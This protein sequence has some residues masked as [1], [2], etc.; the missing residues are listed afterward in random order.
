MIK[1]KLFTPEQLKEV[2]EVARTQN[3][4]KTA[5][6]FKL[7]IES[8]KRIRKAQPKLESALQRGLQH[9]DNKIFTEEEL[10]EVEELAKTNNADNVSKHFNIKLHH[11]AALKRSQ[12]E[13]AKAYQRGVK[14]R[15]YGTFHVGRTTNTT[16]LDQL[17]KPIKITEK[18]LNMSLRDICPQQALSQYM[19]MK[20]A[21]KE[22][23]LYQELREMRNEDL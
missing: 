16:K 4:F 7:N 18:T 11:F 1:D 12:P 13:L 2:E 5:L 23:R 10:L 3:I 14:Q 9:S 19:E 21:E 8:F 6:Y 22:C 15:K 17:S 20:K